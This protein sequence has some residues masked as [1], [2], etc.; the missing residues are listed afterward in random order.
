MGPVCSF[1]LKNKLF[2]QTQNLWKLLDKTLRC[3]MSK[4]QKEQSRHYQNIA[5]MSSSSPWTS[6][7][8]YAPAN[9]TGS[10][11]SVRDF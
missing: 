2:S 10:Q 9:Q 5:M 1:P 7:A 11:T 8:Q 4:K 6:M 3:S